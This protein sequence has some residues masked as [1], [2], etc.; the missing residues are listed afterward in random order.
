[1]AKNAIFAIDT[2]FS[3]GES[4]VVRRYLQYIDRDLSGLLNILR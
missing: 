1:M 4:L 3:Q 2:L